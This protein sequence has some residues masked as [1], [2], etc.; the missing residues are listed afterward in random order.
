MTGTPRLGSVSEAQPGTVLQFDGHH[1]WEFDH[2]LRGP[3]AF[4]GGHA[5]PQIPPGTAE[6]LP[7]CLWFA[8]SGAHFGQYSGPGAA[9]RVSWQVARAL[10]D[11]APLG[12]SHFAG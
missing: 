10:S 2:A 1:R 6:Y 7:V 12:C 4:S 3:A 8:A 9:L 5:D 11:P